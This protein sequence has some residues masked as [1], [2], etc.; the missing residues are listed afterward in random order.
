MNRLSIPGATVVTL[1]E[2]AGR[3]AEHLDG[4]AA[5]VVVVVAAAPLLDHAADLVCNELGQRSKAAPLIRV[6]RTDR[7]RAGALR[8][9]H[10][11][12]WFA[13][14]VDT[15]VVAG[16]QWADDD[17]LD[18][19]VAAA[20]LLPAERSLVV[21]HGPRRASGS[22]AVLHQIARRRGAI[23]VI[24]P[25]LEAT[26]TATTAELTGGWPDL[27]RALDL[28]GS[29]VPTVNERLSLVGDDARS[30]AE[31]LAFGWSADRL[32][33]WPGMD[34]QVVDRL[35]DDLHDEGL[36]HDGE[37]MAGVVAVVRQST[38]AARRARLV[39]TFTE[40][41]QP[42]ARGDL[43]AVLLALDDR[44][45][46][47][48]VLYAALAESCVAV[49][50]PAAGRWL[51]AA[52][53]CG[54]GDD[55]LAGTEARV[56]LA[57]GDAA[58]A[59]RASLQLPERSERDLLRATCFVATGDLTAASG[60]LEHTAYAELRG[61]ASAGVGLPFRA[62][63]ASV[64]ATA[65]IDAG[66]DAWLADDGP[67][68]LDQ[69]KVATIRSAAD[70]DPARWP[71]TARMVHCMVA[72]KFG[73]L[74][75]ANQTM[76]AALEEQA[77]GRSHHHSHLIMSAWLAA[78]RG[79]LDE[80]SATLKLVPAGGLTPQQQ[81]WRACTECAIAVRD[82][83]AESIGAAV[84]AV[85]VAAA[86]V[87][88]HL[89]DLDLVID[90]AAAAVRA[91]GAAAPDLLAPFAHVAMLLEG[92][93]RITAE[94]AW[95]HLAVALASDDLGSIAQRARDMAATASDGQVMAARRQAAD[96]LV[97]ADAGEINASATETSAQ[98][99]GD[100]GAPHEA[101]RLCGV[102]AMASANETDTRR[103]L[104]ASRVWRA[105]RT[106]LRRTSSGDRSVVRLSEQEERVA[107]LVLD[108][109]THKQIGSTLFISAKTVEHHVAHIRT[110]LGAGSRAE[111]LAAIR[112][113]LGDAA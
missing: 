69:L 97:R 99:L 90:A 86:G 14:G 49:D 62:A 2:V 21:L 61:W 46:E 54:V 4:S 77:T 39:H 52:R 101:A 112:H 15:I 89:Y 57:R 110:K 60:A 58:G 33:S 74:V 10:A 92:R 109:H 82:S 71:V 66:I 47:A 7:A 31:L 32:G 36:L 96:L 103:L 70:A 88:A 34:G 104:K 27:E 1:S 55:A 78:R 51:A 73:D 80:A 38:T 24:G 83:E 84:D 53:S 18:D 29:L 12:G 68:A 50:A 43:G 64:T 9:R 81:L 16:A 100:A 30:I 48:G 37:M 102:V 59:L 72:A 111:M 11:G 6:S 91:R 44:S 85:V 5:P 94:L 13:P 40:L 93:P 8:G 19:L 76:E 26:P 17:S 87:T 67:R 63:D 20:D 65:A 23:L 79:R 42:G 107:Q 25:G 113:Y 22:L 35:I 3:A 106:Q 45:A 75:T 105:Q 98:S 41:D 95:A 108:G 28:D 56:L